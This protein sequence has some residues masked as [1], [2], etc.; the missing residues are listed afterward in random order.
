MAPR[1]DIKFLGL[2]I[3]E[4]RKKKRLSQEA[5]AERAR[6][7]YKF[8][9]GIERGQANPTIHVLDNIASALG[10]RLE[11][12]FNFDNFVADARQLRKELSEV[13]KKSDLERL[14]ALRRFVRSL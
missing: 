9:G 2:R 5:L 13:V 10:V 14:Q 7:H 12:L 3:R 8:L 4:L 1:N 11:D 6:I